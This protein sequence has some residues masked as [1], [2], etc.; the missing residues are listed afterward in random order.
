M[1]RF[2]KNSCVL[3]LGSRHFVPRPKIYMKINIIQS[4]KQLQNHDATVNLSEWYNGKVSIV[5]VTAN[6]RIIIN[7]SGYHTKVFTWFCTTHRRSPT[8]CLYMQEAK[9]CCTYTVTYVGKQAILI[10]M[11]LII[12]YLGRIL[13]FMNQTYNWR[14]GNKPNT[15]VAAKQIY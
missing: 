5:Q 14:F 3:L 15:S 9:Y 4:H 10:I 7:L 1:I 2:S 12:G 8:Y 11:P 6:K 13:P